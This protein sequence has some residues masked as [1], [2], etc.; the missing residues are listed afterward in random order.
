MLGAGSTAWGGRE[1]GGL[2][3]CSAGGWEGG[4]AMLC[5]GEGG[6]TGVVCCCWGEGEGG[7]GGWGWRWWVGVV[8][9]C[10]RPPCLHN[11]NKQ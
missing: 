11:T 8:G 2:G 9:P 1:G 10:W 3:G 4:A 6:S 5:L 7:L